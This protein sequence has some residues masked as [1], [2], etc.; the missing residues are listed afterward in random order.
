MEGTKRNATVGYTWSPP[1]MVP[2]FGLIFGIAYLLS[3]IPNADSEIQK[4][5]RLG[6]WGAIG[7]PWAQWRPNGAIGFQKSNQK[8]RIESSVFLGFS[9]AAIKRK[10]VV[11]NHFVLA[12]S[13]AP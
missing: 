7:A 3:R 5:T 1:K 9:R 4:N 2:L 13:G 11:P 12:G 6:A 10:I 8:A